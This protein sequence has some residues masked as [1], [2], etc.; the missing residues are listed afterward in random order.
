MFRTVPYLA[1]NG[2]RI[3]VPTISGS[4]IR[5]LFRRLAAGCFL[6][7]LPGPRL[8]YQEVTALRRGGVITAVSDRANV[9]TAERQAQLKELVLPIALFGGS[10]GGRIVSGSIVIDDAV[11]AVN[12]LQHHAHYYADLPDNYAWPP[13]RD[14]M[15]NA[16]HTRAVDVPY[17]LVDPTTLGAVARKTNNHG[18]K[19]NDPSM[20]G[21]QIYSYQAM[22]PGTVL[23]HQMTVEAATPLVHSFMRDVMA[24]WCRNATVGG[25]QAKGYGK[26]RPNYTVSHT[27]VWGE[28]C[29]PPDYVDWRAWV[30]A[31]ELDIREALSW[32]H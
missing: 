2:S 15:F 31:Y 23:W 28:A 24:L 5:G 14:I 1:E 16:E 27:N 17:H 4:N 10:G 7:A 11:P 12:E 3:A 20:D 18:T 21:K 22:V 8:P 26:V 32:M 25:R 30:H 6:D 9:L 19:V 13:V 29:D